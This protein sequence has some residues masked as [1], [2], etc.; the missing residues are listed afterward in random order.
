MS[1]IRFEDF[2]FR[3]PNN[4]NTLSNITLDVDEGEFILL[5][6]PS[7][8]GKT[9]LL[10]NLKNEIRPKGDSNGIIYYDGENIKDLEDEKSASQIGFLFQ[11]PEDQMVSDNVLQEIAFPL[12]N[13]GLSTS[14]IR[15]RVAEMTAF[16]GLDKQL[17]KKVN[18][19]SGGQK[20]LVNLCSLLVLKPRLLL[21]DEPTSQLDPIA[22]YD[23]LS[24]LRRLNEEFSITIIATEH[25]I[26]NMFP[27]IDKAVFLRD[28]S[29]KYCDKPRSICSEAWKDNIFSNYLPYVTRINFLLQSKY[30]FLGELDIPLNIREGRANL[31]LLNN[32]LK[33]SQTSLYPID[34]TASINLTISPNY[35]KEEN[36]EDENGNESPVNSSQNTMISCKDIWFGYVLKNIVLKGISIDIH[37][38]EF[39]SILGGN[40]TGKTTLLQ[41]LAGLIKAKKGKVN[42]RKNLKLGYV[43]QNPMIHFRQETVREEFSEFP[44]EI[45]EN[46]Q[47]RIKTIDNPEKG[48][49]IFKSIFKSKKTN[50]SMMES[51]KTAH[52]KYLNSSPNAL[53]EDEK[54]QFEDE[55][56]ELIELFGLSHLLD[57]HPYD[58]SGGEQQ[59]N[60]HCKSSVNTP[61][62]SVFG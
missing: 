47:S 50:D 2:S 15:N 51:S 54:I 28:G 5:C 52:L 12:E 27:F 42:Y 37:Q 13:M 32:E 11:N 40:G 58:C 30:D 17:Y 18:E 57:K 20:Q 46:H 53:F 39:I 19:L 29:I 45:T 14:E 8:S 43:H 1:L 44:P 9:T 3:Y 25:K 24:I 7:G 55:K 34:T 6:G 36:G 56:M 49:K 16:F 38:G 23:F 41:I 48:F 33:K 21:L 59:K 26:D 31:N 61:R 60:S 22:A 35:N 10:T 62:Y 4:E